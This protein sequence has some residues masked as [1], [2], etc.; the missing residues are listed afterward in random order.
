MELKVSFSPLICAGLQLANTN[1]TICRQSTTVGATDAASAKLVF[2]SDFNARM[3]QHT[4][5]FG[6]KVLLFQGP[7]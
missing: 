2:A 1:T 4:A 3:K 6:K 5:W 7:L